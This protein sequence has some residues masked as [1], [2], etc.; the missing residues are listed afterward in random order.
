MK[1]LV[2]IIL[3]CCSVLSCVK[4][5]DFEQA[6]DLTFYPIL[7]LSLVNFQQTA[8]E[9]YKGHGRDQVIVI[10]DTLKLDLFSG[11]F[12]KENLTKAELFFDVKNSINRP[13]NV[14]VDFF[15]ATRKLRHTINLDT[16][17]SKTGEDVLTEHLETFVNKQLDNLTASEQLILT[18]SML[19]GNTNANQDSGRIKMR[20]KATFYYAINTAD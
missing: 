18:F 1:S 7:K 16:K 5:V 8:P 19:K 20:S 6:E 2:I 12:S 4:D 14:K 11:D 3:I 10:R 13:F 17:A 15:D 9:F